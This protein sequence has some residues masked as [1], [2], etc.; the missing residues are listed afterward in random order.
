MIT[1]FDTSGATS[2]KVGS[3][4]LLMLVGLGVGGF[5]LWKYVIKPKMDENKEDK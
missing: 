5:L 3:S 1:Q 2:K 4:K